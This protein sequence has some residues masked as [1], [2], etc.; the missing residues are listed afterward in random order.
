MMWLKRGKQPG[1]VLDSGTHNMEPTQ[2]PES[3][4]D[5][6]TDPST[7]EGLKELK[8]AKETKDEEQAEDQSSKD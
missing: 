1:S 4:Y 3:I 2:I 8:Q 7:L 5:I 6:L